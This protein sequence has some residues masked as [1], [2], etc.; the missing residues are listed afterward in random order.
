MQVSRII[1]ASRAALYDSFMSAE[2]L[3]AWLP[4]RGMRGAVDRF[5]PREGGGYRMTLTYER[6]GPETPGKTTADSDTVKVRFV[7]LV[8]GERIV[9]A[10]EFDSEDPG[11]AGVMIMTWSFADAPGGTEVTVLVE[12]APPGISEQDHETGIRSSLDNLAA[13]VARR[14]RLC[15]DRS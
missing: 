11:A 6:P 14:R 13:F 4:P 7:R 1:P 15:H 2:A 10:A 8:P 9:Q 5:D 3:V 12:N